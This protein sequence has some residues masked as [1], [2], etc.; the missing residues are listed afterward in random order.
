MHVA[1]DG[2]RHGVGVVEIAG[3]VL[4]TQ[5][6][7]VGPSLLFLHG[8]DGLRWSGPAIDALAEVFAV[9]ATH[10]PAWGASTRPDHVRDIDDLAFI[11]RELIE[12]SPEPVILV[13]CSFGGWLAAEIAVQ[14][15]ANLAAVV[16]VAPTGIKLGARDERDFTDIWAANFED[17]PGILYSDPAKA[18]DLTDLSDEDYLELATAQEAVARYCWK[19]YMYDPKLRHRLRRIEVPTLVISG[20]ADGFSLAPDYYERYAALIGNGAAFEALGDVGHRVEEEAPQVLADRIVSFARQ[21]SAHVPTGV[22]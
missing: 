22:S 8:E 3:A 21:A 6:Q 19:P 13:G 20:D 7:G 17:L 14:R 12:Q 1:D 5:R 10:H 4:D 2:K 15:P 16:L 18:P 11:Y 9:T